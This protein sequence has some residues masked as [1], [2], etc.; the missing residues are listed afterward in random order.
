MRKWRFVHSGREGGA[1]ECTEYSQADIPKAF[2]GFASTRRLIC[3]PYISVQRRAVETSLVNGAVWLVVLR[4][5][6]ALLS[7][8]RIK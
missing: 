8:S 4:S 6:S 2:L 1:L 5:S 7:K 3:C